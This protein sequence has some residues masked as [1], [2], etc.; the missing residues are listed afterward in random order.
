M[1][2]NDLL[3]RYQSQ[4]RSVPA[5]TVE[6]VQARIEQV[7]QATDRLQALRQFILD[8]ISQMSDGVLVVDPLGNIILSNE[9]ALHYL[10]DNHHHG[11][12]ETLL[13]EALAVLQIQGTH[14]WPGLL[15]EV[16][17]EHRN[18]QIDAQHKNGRDLLVQIVPLDRSKRELGGLIVNLSDISPLKSSERKR[19][20]LLGFLSHDLRSPLV[21]LLALLEISRSKNP[22][23]ELQTLLDRMEG[24]A[25]NTIN[26][27]EEFL[28]L[29]H[30][31][32]GEN[33]QFN[34]VDLM[35]VAYN[36][37]EHVW[38]QAEKKEISLKHNFSVDDAWIHADANLIERALVNLLNNA[39]K[40]SHPQTDV[41]LS[42]EKTDTDY[43][44]C[45]SDQGR[46]IPQQ[47]L[48]HLFDRFYRVSQ[49]DIEAQEKGAGLGLAFVQAVSERHSGKITVTSKPGEGSEFCLILPIPSS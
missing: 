49:D 47:E 4:S 11:L 17:L 5:D 22:D 24:Y 6:L 29:A 34:D 9:R 2:L 40:Y 38:A 33:I 15:Q 42:L 44:C 35:S 43:L 10:E 20:E 46:G 3:E 18:I 7:Q 1:L 25:N 13:T 36:A 30:A 16:L 28:Q 12:N 21:S 8:V 26:L 14:N 27:A 37:L 32:S 45:I 39:I 48:H 19:S 41:I 23:P 31:E